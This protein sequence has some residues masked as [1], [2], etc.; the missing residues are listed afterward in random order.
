MDSKISPIEQIKRCIEKKQNFVLQG[1]AGSGKTETLKHILEYISTEMPGK[2][3]ACITHTNLA[4]DEII[5][6]VGNNYTISTIHSFLNS[7]I[8]NYKKNIHIVL[9]DLFRLETIERLDLSNYESQKEQNKIEHNKYKKLHEKFAR[10]LYIVR[11]ESIEKAVGKREYDK[12]PSSFNKELN[13][14]IDS[15]NSEILQII[16]SKDF[17][18]VKYNETRYDN[19]N[20]LTF[21]HD[22]LLKVSALLFERYSLLSRIV[23][24]K[25]DFIFIDEYQDTNKQIVDIFLKKMAS[26][27]TTIGLF[28]DSMQGIYDDGIGNVNDYIKTGILK[29]IEKED[30]F[31]CSEQVVNFIKKLRNDNLNQQVALKLKNGI[32]EKIEDRQGEIKLFYSVY[33]STKPHPRSPKEEKE[34]YTAFVLSLLK[35]VEAANPNYKKLMLTN[36]SISREV[37]FQNLYEIFDDR[38]SD[39]KDEI[40]KELT[41]LQL[42]DLAELCMAYTSQEQKYN[43]IITEIKKA[44]FILKTVKDKNKIKSHFDEILKSR[45]NAIEVLQ[46]AFNKKLIKVSDSYSSYINRKNEFL[47]GLDSNND[48]QNFKTLYTTG[49]NTFA[50]ILEENPTMEKGEFKEFEKMLR[51]ESYFENIFSDKLK[52]SEILNYF[53]YLNEETEYITMHKTKGS[54]IENVL[55]VLDE[56]FWTQYNFKF[57]FDTTPENQ[58]RRLKNQK[59]FYVACSRAIQN[60]IVIKAVSDED[61]GILLTKHFDNVE[62]V[63]LK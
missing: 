49:S 50:R 1:G 9:Y 10:R 33:G 51:K 6:R 61:E 58:E 13:E 54:G 7:L 37:G 19:F 31:R 63:E 5:A 22:S 41:R 20:D 25:Y 27:N 52:F 15:L 45:K 38:Y 55:I 46:I 57:L 59:L 24:D 62:K 26:N 60:L 56:F 47:K 53:K 39:V 12:T 43:F 36:K 21:G 42:I 32:P 29:K 35:K 28:G 30:N 23:Q 16:K 2:K 40:E 4:V 17:N 8:K 44:G 3:I 14:N 18:K 48:Y 34:K 11:K